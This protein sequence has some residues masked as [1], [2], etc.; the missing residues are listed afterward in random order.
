MLAK[1]ENN[2]SSPAFEPKNE[3]RLSGTVLSQRDIILSH[4]ILPNSYTHALFHLFTDP[5]QATESKEPFNFSFEKEA[6]T[7]ES[8]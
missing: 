3:G 4:L 8:T 1:C 6:H 5:K 2:A 7:V